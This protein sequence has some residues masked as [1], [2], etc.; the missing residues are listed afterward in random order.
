MADK[1]EEQDDELSLSDMLDTDDIEYATVPAWKKPNGAQGTV[2]IRSLTAGDMIQFVQTNE[3]PAK[4]TAGV[5]LI[6]KSVVDK[7]GNLMF[8][9]DDLTKLKKRNSKITNS[10]VDAI[11]KLNGLDKKTQDAAKNDS[12]GTEPD[13][14]PTVLH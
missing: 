8:K 1:I 6:I 10:I 7:H 12:G 13:A 2:R 14:S 11:L 4:H 5:R 3:G 9:D